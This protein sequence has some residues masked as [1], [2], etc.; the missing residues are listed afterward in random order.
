MKK[1]TP[2]KHFLRKLI[3]ESLLL[4][5]GYWYSQ[6]QKKVKEFSHAEEKEMEEYLGGKES[7]LAFW[8]NTKQLIKDFFIPHE[9]NDHKPKSLHPKTLALYLLA[10]LL[11]K[12]A[13]TGILFFVYPN[14][15]E[16]SRIFSGEIIELA[17]QARKAE[18]LSPLRIDPILT[19]TAFQKG[20]DML[21]REYF[22]HDSPDGKKPWM[23][24]DKKKYDFVYA[25]ENLALDFI[26]SEGVH[27][28]FMKSPGHRRNILNENYMDIGVAVING[29]MFGK[30]TDLL[31]QFF[32]TQRANLHVLEKQKFSYRA[33]EKEEKPNIQ[34][35]SAVV[36][37]GGKIEEVSMPREDS[38]INNNGIKERVAN[39]AIFWM[40]V[41]F[42][43]LL[44]FMLI[45]L[46]MNIVIKFHIQH[47]SVI[48]QTLVV[49]AIISI[50]LL[51]KLHFMENITS[52]IIIL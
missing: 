16:M 50:L 52:Q 13:G 42:L 35:S 12:L 9:G 19:Q 37:R 39:R 14:Q 15:A 20:N 22:A 17:N 24:I 49:V 7:G 26:T 41:F 23:W 29:T 38:L 34:S 5:L 30:E 47:G 6:N 48:M 10:A 40:N 2:K 11:I 27:E 3:F 21:I 43:S 33:R 18:G 44:I 51:T 31:V 25:G 45:L 28:A 36:V 4:F 1:K 8:K 32:G 46:L